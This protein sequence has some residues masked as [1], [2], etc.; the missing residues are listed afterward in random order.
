MVGAMV[1]PYSGRIWDA[2]KGWS[3]CGCNQTPLHSI[4]VLCYMIPIMWGLLWQSHQPNCRSQITT[5]PAHRCACSSKYH[6]YHYYPCYWHLLP[7]LGLVIT[8]SIVIIITISLC[9]CHYYQ[10]NNTSYGL[11]IMIAAVII[12][13]VILIV[14]ILTIVIVLM[15]LNCCY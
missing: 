3:Y 10:N 1:G 13:I 14:I 15:L 4:H 9:I 6:Y 5:V 8:I 11:M 12:T 2:K 7:L